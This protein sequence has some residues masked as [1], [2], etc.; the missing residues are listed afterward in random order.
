MQPPAREGEVEGGGGLHRLVRPGLGGGH[1]V[2]EAPEPLP[3]GYG[4]V[5]VDE[6]EAG[7]LQGVREEDVALDVTQID[8]H[9]RHDTFSAC[10]ADQ[11]WNSPIRL[12]AA[13]PSVRTAKSMKAFRSLRTDLTFPRLARA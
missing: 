5:E 2:D 7:F 3:P 12:P 9:G 13:M 1:L 10:S 4:V 8:L 6:V 11:A